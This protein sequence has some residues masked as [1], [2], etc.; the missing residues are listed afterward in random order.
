MS[1][2]R[3]IY[4]QFLVALLPLVAIIGYLAFAGDD[5][6]QRVDLSLSAYDQA[7]GAGNA[8]KTFLDGLTDAVDTGRLSSAA[9]S[10]LGLS[11]EHERRLGARFAADR[12]L[13][14]RLA[15]LHTSVASSPKVADLLPLRDE[16]QSLRK[17]LQQSADSRRQDLAAL[18]REQELAAQRRRGVV[19]IAALGAVVVAAF[20]G[21]VLKRL[22]DG[23]T[24]PLATSVGVAHAIAAGQLDGDIGV[25]GQD[26]MAQLLAAMR[27][28]QANLLD[29]VRAVRAGAESVAAGSAS[30]SADTEGLSQRAEQEAASLQQA[31]VSMEEISAT[32]KQS[33]EHAR[34]AYDLAERAARAAA[35][36]GEAARRVTGTMDQITE[37][38]KRIAEIVSVIDGIS[39][40]TN[41]LA[42][43]AA[44]EAAR[45]GEHGRGFAVVAGE[46]RALSQRCAT[47][48]TEI[49]ALI[50]TSV[51]KVESGGHEV[52]AAGT[53]IAELV[54]NVQRVCA[55][56]SDIARASDE[57][58]RRIEQVSGA[59]TEMDGVVQKNAVAV[60][61]GA[62]AAAR[63]TQ[64]ARSLA[65]IVSRFRL[66]ESSAEERSALAPSEDPLRLR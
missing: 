29:I 51:A 66:P 33:S 2:R 58:D 56:M 10:A 25:G 42:L 9:V 31:A 8:Y 61:R 36:G 11:E 34:Q 1:L 23:I 59:V 60:H 32:V 63:L 64:D 54:E 20:I 13:A 62:A 50:T 19:W 49:K 57:Q 48:A 16:V 4:A 40:Q 38:S 43:N 6:P 30:L 18:V 41:I 22:V 7:L 53:S 35:A 46:V 65:Q 24:R 28:M 44:I 21:L 39:F 47:A 14:E 5:L 12:E 3:R 17:G 55:L 37:D 27:T 15:R 52:T 45:A 26:E